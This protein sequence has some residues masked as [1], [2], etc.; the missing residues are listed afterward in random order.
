MGSSYLTVSF[1]PAWAMDNDGGGDDDQLKIQ[2]VK[3]FFTINLI[4]IGI[5]I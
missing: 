2:D 5:L 3:F 4:V 1:M